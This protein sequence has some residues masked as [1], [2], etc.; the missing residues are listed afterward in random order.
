MTLS[1]EGAENYTYQTNRK[2]TY[3]LPPVGVLKLIRLLFSPSKVPKFS[4][5]DTPT[6]VILYS[7]PGIKLCNSRLVFAVVKLTPLGSGGETSI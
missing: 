4:P 1:I 7:V 2:C 3:D 5:M 6:T